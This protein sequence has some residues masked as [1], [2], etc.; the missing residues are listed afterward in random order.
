MFQAQQN[1]RG[2]IKYKKKQYKIKIKCVF[3]NKNINLVLQKNNRY[4][5]IILYNKSK[6]ICMFSYL[7]TWKFKIR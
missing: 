6:I 2:K 7:N 5:I 4:V 3:K 1:L